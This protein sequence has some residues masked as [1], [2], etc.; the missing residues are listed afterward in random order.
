M[1]N[2][3]KERKMN[4]NN[5]IKPIELSETDEQK[6]INVFDEWL[7]KEDIL[8]LVVF[9]GGPKIEGMIENA[10]SLINDPGN[11]YKVA[12]VIWANNPNF[13]TGR[14]KELEE[15]SH[16]REINWD[17]FG[18]IAMVAITSENNIIAEVILKQEIDQFIKSRI[19]AAVV[20]GLGLDNKSI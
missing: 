18:N 14:L 4:N 7:L 16:L 12:R 10:N 20:L 11:F 8:L 13:I 19:S 9:G 5:F 1:K 15:D 3:K 6:A 2:K 17:N